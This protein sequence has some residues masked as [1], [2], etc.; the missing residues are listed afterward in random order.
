MTDEEV[1]Q[2][3]WEGSYSYDSKSYNSDPITRFK[4]TDGYGGRDCMD[5]ASGS[6]LQ[7]A[8]KTAAEKARQ[9]LGIIK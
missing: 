6:S 7:A 3:V 8:I 1:I 2:K 5:V 9:I 4:V